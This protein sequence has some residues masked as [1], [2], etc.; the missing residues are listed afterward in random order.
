MTNLYKY[1][2]SIIKNGCCCDDN[3]PPPPP[4]CPPSTCDFSWIPMFGG[5]VP[6]TVDCGE[7]CQCE[8]F[9]IN[10]PG[11]G[12]PEFLSYPCVPIT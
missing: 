8:S 9:P 5:W 6:L 2:G 4:E 12:D 3:P 11:P 7:S 10:P 1:N